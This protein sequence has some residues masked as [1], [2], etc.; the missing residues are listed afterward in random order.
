MAA[1]LLVPLL[2]AASAAATERP[3]C[4]VLAAPVAAGEA[5]VPSGLIP[6]ACRPGASRAPLR[7]DRAGGIVRA[8]ADLEA[9]AYLGRIALPAPPAVTPGEALTLVSTVG[10]VTIRRSVVALQ[11]AKA[12]ER[13]FVRDEEGQV[14]SVAL[15][16]ADEG[17]RP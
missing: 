1:L 6:A 9:G 17:E 10:P 8:E 5:L 4:S 11:P 12:G 13:L 2:L 3:G 7:L 15:A 16:P 14:T